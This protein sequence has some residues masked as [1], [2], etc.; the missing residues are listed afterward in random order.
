MGT[1]VLI[2][3]RSLIRCIGIFSCCDDEG[4]GKIGGYDI[5]VGNAAAA[6]AAAIGASMGAI[7]GGGGGGGGG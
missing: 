1:V 4:V 5:V 3:V 2:P 7:G 6:A